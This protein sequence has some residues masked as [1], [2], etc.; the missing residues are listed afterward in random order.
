MLGAFAAGAVSAIAIA[1]AVSSSKPPSKTAEHYVGS[2][3]A[4]FAKLHMAAAPED[5][6]AGTTQSSPT[7]IG[8]STEGSPRSAPPSARKPSIGAPADSEPTGVSYSLQASLE[9]PWK[10]SHGEAGFN[11]GTVSSTGLRVSELLLL[12]VPHLRKL[13]P[14]ADAHVRNVKRGEGIT[15]AAAAAPGQGALHGRSSF[16]M[17]A[18]TVASAAPAE[19]ASSAACDAASTGF[20]SFTRDDSV[21]VGDIVRSGNQRSVSRAYL[22]AGPR[23]F[24]YFKPQEVRAAIIT[25]GGACLA[26]G[27]LAPCC[28]LTT[29]GHSAACSEVPPAVGLQH[30]QLPFAPC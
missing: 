12:D 23:E 5:G 11:L 1:K 25:C 28:R 24:L 27:S 19:S 18:S 7:A 13:N 2:P 8:A 4:G 17:K 15:A 3:L 10:V 26:S 20:I 29:V 6:R 9:E 30:R 21:V 22:R 16:A 14:E